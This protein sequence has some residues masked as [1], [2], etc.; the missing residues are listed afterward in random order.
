[1]SNELQVMGQK[2]ELT[3]EQVDLL[4][5]TICRGSTDDELKMFIGIANKTGLDPFTK[6]IYAVK[7]WDSKERREVMAVQT[8]IDGFRLIAART[9]EYEG[10][11]G[12]FW[13]G[14]DGNWK[15]AWLVSTNPVAAK[16]GVWRKGFR[17]PLWGVARFRA[18]A[19]TNKEGKLTTF[20]EKMPDVMIAKVAESLAL[21]K[22]F[23]NE[24]SGLYTA[25][26]MGQ[27]DNDGGNVADKTDAKKDAL[28]EKIG[29]SKK[30]QPVVMPALETKEAEAVI[31]K[32]NEPVTIPL[33][34]KKEA[35]EAELDAAFDMVEVPM[36]NFDS[37]VV[38]EPAPISA[39]DQVKKRIEGSKNMTELRA[40]WAEFTQACGD[41]SINLKDLPAKEAQKVVADFTALK[42]K[43]KKE[44]DQQNL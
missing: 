3:G 9:G 8:S 42:D 17:E 12:P 29:G 37:E 10:Q 27:A 30:A 41:G 13:C 33:V 25:D 40:A 19:Q 36:S 7:R 5:R 26:E 43:K 32:A 21:R 11:V 22:A 38:L 24:L 34:T 39:M 44:F 23:P 2:N 35:R 14:E 28:K 15:D 16:V 4:K 6:Q 20:W 31:A 1:M 18:Y